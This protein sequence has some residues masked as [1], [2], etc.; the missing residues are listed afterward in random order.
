[1]GKF[2]IYSQGNKLDG[3]KSLAGFTAEATGVFESLRT[4]GQKIFRL[5][6][7]LE[8]LAESAK[9]TGFDLSLSHAEQEISLALAAYCAEN[10]EA[11][12]VF[13][14]ITFSGS[15]KC[16]VMIGERRHL[17][18]LYKTGVSLRTSPVRRSLSNASPPE[19]KTSAY[20]NAVMASLEPRAAGTYEWVFLDRDGY[21]TEVRIGNLFAVVRGTSKGRK[22]ELV[23]PPCLGILNGVTRRFVLDCAS[24]AGIPVR[25]IPLTRHDLYNAGEVFLTNTSWEILPV[26]ELDGRRTGPKVP[27]PVTLKLH[28]IFRQKIK[29]E[30]S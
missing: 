11:K 10:R 9:T 23:T 14:R 22:P 13:I 19:V 20:Q 17:Q 27:G 25:E 1:M 2:A 3:K 12:D 8:R 7:H 28:R 30:C 16:F 15:R 5:E 4:Y 21:V 26:R 29:E 24:H 18:V 6:E